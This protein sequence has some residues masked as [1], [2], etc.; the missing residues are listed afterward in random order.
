MNKMKKKTAKKTSTIEKFIH[1]T[2]ESKK[3]DIVRLMGFEEGKDD[4]A[5][6]WAKVVW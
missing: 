3:G 6:A 2:E 4:K 5:V 1:E